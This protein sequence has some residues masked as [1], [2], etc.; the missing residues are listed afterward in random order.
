MSGRDGRPSHW[1]HELFESAHGKQGR[2]GGPRG[3]RGQGGSSTWELNR[4]TARRAKT[5]P[6]S[7]P[8]ST[9]SLHGRQ[10]DWQ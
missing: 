8:S 2:T 9:A 7:A 4:R 10:P 3:E 6:V 1:R 5:L